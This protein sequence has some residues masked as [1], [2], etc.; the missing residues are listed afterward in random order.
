MR[1]YSQVNVLCRDTAFDGPSVKLLDHLGEGSQPNAN[2]LADAE[3]F[4]RQLYNKG[5][6]EVHVNKE[7]TTAFRKTRKNFATPLTTC[8]PP[9]PDMEDGPSTVS[10]TS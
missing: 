1:G 4:V 7:G 9:G 6:E 3:A 8:Q 10:Y 2:V 5:T